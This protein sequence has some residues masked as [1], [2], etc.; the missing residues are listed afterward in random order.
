M[1]NF[2]GP[3]IQ[4]IRT[5]TTTGMACVKE[6]LTFRFQRTYPKTLCLIWVRP[7][8]GGHQYPYAC[9]DAHYTGGG[10]FQALGGFWINGIADCDLHPEQDFA[11]PLRRANYNALRGK[12]PDAIGD[13]TDYLLYTTIRD[14]I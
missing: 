13:T 9:Q 6:N 8:I 1:A 11:S 12:F 3:M 7:T 4:N 5:W 10:A 14:M 2:S